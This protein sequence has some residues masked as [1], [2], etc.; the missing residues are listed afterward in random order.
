LA[1]ISNE[2]VRKTYQWKTYPETRRQLWRTARD[3][4]AHIERA[5]EGIKRLGD[6]NEIDWDALAKDKKV[7]MTEKCM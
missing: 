2:A 5:E 7:D 6:E 3:A 1:F 4:Q